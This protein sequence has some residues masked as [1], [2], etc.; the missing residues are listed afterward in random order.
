[1]PPNRRWSRRR[2]AIELLVRI[3]RSPRLSANAL[4]G[5][6][7]ITYRCMPSRRE[8]LRAHVEA[9]FTQDAVGRLVKVNE[10]GGKAA[11]RFFL[12]RTGDGIACWFRHDLPDEAVESLEAAC[13]AVPDTVDVEPPGVTVA[14]FEAILR[15]TAPVERVWSGPA[16]AFPDLR[17]PGPLATLITKANADLLRPLMDSWSEDVERNAPLF[18]V[19]VGGQAV[20]VCASVR[21]S[22]IADEAGVETASAFRGKGYGAHAVNAW[23]AA[24]VQLNR[25]P[26]Y[27]TSWANV[28]SRA[29]AR[30]LGLVQFASDLHIT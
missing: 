6:T 27:S 5:N 16:F 29:L 20:S 30:K 7:G 22:P 13:A 15:H 18:A 25:V 4:G 2:S 17:R 1:M 3:D 10:P 14:P 23:A 26:L 28:A 24:V 12:G 9:L 8:L 21:R 11:P 19:V